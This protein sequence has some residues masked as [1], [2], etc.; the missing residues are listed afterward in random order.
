MDP[1]S[2][3]LGPPLAGHGHPHFWQR[4]L[5][6]G[7]FLRTAA[8]VGGVAVGAGLGLPRLTQAAFSRGVLAKPIPGGNYFL[9]PGTE[10]FHVFGPAPGAELSSITDFDGVIGAAHLQ[11]PAIQTLAD[12]STTTLYCDY[13]MRFMKGLY[14]G[15]DG[16]A[17]RGT[18][19]FF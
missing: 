3:S 7:Q 13:D 9:G 16:R 15:V 1:T 2:R 6:R 18:F 4:A 11:G 14:I 8:G 12:G 10:L 19:S 5:S 17:H